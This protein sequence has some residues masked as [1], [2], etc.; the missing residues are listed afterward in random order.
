MYVCDTVTV[1]FTRKYNSI[2]YN[3]QQ[4]G[5]PINST[6]IQ[7]IILPHMFREIVIRNHTT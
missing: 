7:L 1:L 5:K 4:Y 2:E 3:T 6:T